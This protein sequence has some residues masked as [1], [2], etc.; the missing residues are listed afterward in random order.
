MET[1]H[2]YKTIDGRGFLNIKSKLTDKEM[3]GYIEISK[4][5]FKRLT[6]IPEPTAEQKAKRE[7]AK[8]IASLKKQLA[9]TD[10]QAIKYAEGWITEE[11]YAPIKA[12][13]Q[14]LRDQIN[15]LEG[16]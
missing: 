15:E 7:K 5:E 13:R 2:Y 1:R 14:A 3:N 16:N 10:Y 8:Q 12:A 9:E 4:E 11:E 6:A